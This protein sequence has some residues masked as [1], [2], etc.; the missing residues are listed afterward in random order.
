M[1]RGTTA[2]F[3]FRM[4][5]SIKDISVI[6]ITFW[7]ENYDGPSKIR[8][9]PIIKSKSQCVQNIFNNE[10]LVCLDS[11]ETLRFKDDRKAYVQLQGKTV[12]GSKFGSKKGLITVYPVYDDSI[13]DDNITPTPTP[14]D[15]GLI[16]LDGNAIKQDAEALFVF[17][18]PDI[19]NGGD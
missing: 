19:T 12:S 5:Y 8:P 11:E 7:Q 10:I 3:K 15:N 16:I 14:E 13:L 1:I 4:P 2:Q 17:E 18:G 9:L 6:K